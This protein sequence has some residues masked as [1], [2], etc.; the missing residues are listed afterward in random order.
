MQ[1][2]P[3]SSVFCASNSVEDCAI[4]KP[5]AFDSVTRRNMGVIIYYGISTEN[6]Y[7]YLV[8]RFRF[9]IPQGLNPLLIS[10]LHNYFSQ[11]R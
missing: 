11:K 4:G 8:I 1:G 9:L 5:K 3:C 7:A 10:K 6:F 2:D